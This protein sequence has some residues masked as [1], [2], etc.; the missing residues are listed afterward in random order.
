[1]DR[2]LYN[3][4]LLTET[5]EYW[6]TSISSFSYEERDGEIFVPPIII[7]GSKL[8]LVAM[9]EV[10]LFYLLPFRQYMYCQQNFSGACGTNIK[11]RQTWQNRKTLISTITSYAT[12][13]TVSVSF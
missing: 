4:Q 2:N 5:I 13:S 1:M 3:V 10:S 11:F 6:L 9:D 7:V 8:D 12:R